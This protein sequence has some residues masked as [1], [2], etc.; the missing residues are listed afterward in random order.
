MIPF[1]YLVLYTNRVLGLNAVGYGLLLSA[2]ALGGLLGSWVAGRIRSRIGYGWSIVA[3]LTLGAAAFA[4]ISATTNIVVVAVALAVYICH[5]VVWNVLAS[6]VR[7]KIVPPEFMGRVGS[8]SKLL[9][10]IGLA[11][12]ALAG[13]WLAGTFGLRFPFAAAA[14]LFAGASLLCVITMG[15]FRI[16]ERAQSSARIAE[17]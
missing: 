16:W 8:V 5:A 10:L 9:G 12:G 4:V 11:I 1:S 15:Q 7:Q 13:G 2:S 3:A 14:V 6:S 17:L